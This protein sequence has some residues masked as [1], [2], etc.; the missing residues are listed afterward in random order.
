MYNV[1]GDVSWTKGAILGL[2]LFAL[3]EVVSLPAMA[4]QTNPPV[5]QEPAW[6]SPET[7]ALAVRACYDCHSNE[8]KW[9]WY[10]RTTPAG[11]LIAYDVNEG[12]TALNFS[13]WG[14]SGEEGEEMAETILEGEMPLWFYVPLHP[15]ARLS[16]AEQQ[17]LVQGL[18][19]LAGG[20]GE[21]HENSDYE[22][23]DN[24]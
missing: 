15:E 13:E 17:Q 22:H 5:V 14:T 1:F 10:A 4:Q 21:K 23:G 9:P 7:R 16:A 3:I 18:Q 2:I 6:D 11:W 20:E 24:D 12:R 19:Q 8:T